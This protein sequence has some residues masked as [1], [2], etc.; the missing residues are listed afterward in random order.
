MKRVRAILMICGLL[1]TFCCDGS[2]STNA[3]LCSF[4]CNEM[5][6]AGLDLFELKGSEFVEDLL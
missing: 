5:F 4:S 1:V 2:E 6:F 3:G